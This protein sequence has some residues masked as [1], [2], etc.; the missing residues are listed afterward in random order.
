MQLY[1][2]IVSQ[3]QVVK[4]FEVGTIVNKTF[5]SC[6]SAGVKKLRIRAS[7]SYAGLSERK[8]LDIT[9]KNTYYRKFNA[10]FT[11]N[12]TLRNE[13]ELDVMEQILVDLVDLSNQRVEY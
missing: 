7:E 4:Q 2:D 1:H 12:T 5:N 11:N 6:K 9:N 8:I 3:L 13:G 10:K